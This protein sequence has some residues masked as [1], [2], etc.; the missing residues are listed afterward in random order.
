M[1]YDLII[2]G[3]GPAGLTASI[4]A[5]RH[6]MKHLVFESGVVGGQIASATDVENWP[7]DKSVKGAELARRMEEQAKC[8]GMEVRAQPV[9]DIVKDEANSCFCC[10]C[11]NERFQAKS[12]IIAMGAM[13]RKLGV[14]GEDKFVGRGISYCATCDAAFFREKVVA[15]IGGGDSALTTAVYLADYASKVYVIHRRGEFRAQEANQEKARKNQKVEFVLNSVVKEVKGEKCVKSALIENV[16]TKGV[17]ELLLDGIFVYIGNTPASAI[18]KRV[19][20]ETDAKSYIK[21]D[22]EMR[23]SV[24]GIFA[25][26]D[27]TGSA[28]Q[29]IVAAGQGA[30][31]AMAAYKF[32]KGFKEDIAVINR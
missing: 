4:Y 9:G 25:A 23:T 1:V 2:I 7:G 29:A 21:V 8:L 32:V 27:V 3:A 26:G 30:I 18:G 6:R 13:H 11:G 24:P 14:V 5:S 12:V 17:S 28:P 15:V 22:S 19:G 31:A 20:V 16:E 10:V